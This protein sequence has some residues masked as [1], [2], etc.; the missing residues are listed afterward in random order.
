MCAGEASWTSCGTRQG[1]GILPLQQCSD[2]C[3]ICPPEFL[4][5]E[6]FNRGLGCPSWQWN[7]ELLL[8]RPPGPLFF[9]PSLWLLLSRDRRS[10]R[11]RKREGRGI[12]GERSSFD[13]RE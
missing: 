7:P 1:Y 2:R 4:P 10:K 11:V 13:R 8:R 12:H 3:P 6:D 9:Y 5:S